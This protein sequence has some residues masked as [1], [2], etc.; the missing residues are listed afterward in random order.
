MFLLKI[1]SRTHTSHVKPE[2]RCN[3]AEEE[4]L[5]C[6][7][8]KKLQFIL[9]PFGNFSRF[10]HI[11]CEKEKF[12]FHD[13][14]RKIFPI[15]FLFIKRGKPKCLPFFTP[16]SFFTGR[17]SDEHSISLSVF[18]RQANIEQTL[19]TRFDE[20]DENINRDKGGKSAEFRKKEHEIELLGN[21]LRYLKKIN[22]ELK[23][24]Q[25]QGKKDFD[26]TKNKVAKCEVNCSLYLEKLSMLKQWL[27]CSIEHFLCKPLNE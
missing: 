20:N 3:T 24:K 2:V 25:R 18:H 5:L 27:G 9:N 11:Y 10:K 23:K 21:E 17:F 1:L 19:Q 14:V 6:F 7:I 15:I 13:D 26:C 12:I 16:I 8:R 22:E 4:S